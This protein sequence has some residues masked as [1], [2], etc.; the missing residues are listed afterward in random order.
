MIEYLTLSQVAEK[1]GVTTRT[2]L[3]MI[4][5]DRFPKPFYVGKRARWVESDLDEFFTSQRVPA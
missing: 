4:Q 3:N 1:L 5:G 2:I